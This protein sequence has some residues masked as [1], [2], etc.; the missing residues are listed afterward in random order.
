MKSGGSENLNDSLIQNAWE[1]WLKYNKYY[2]HHLLK[3]SF[4][5][6]QSKKGKGDQEYVETDA[7]AVLWTDTG[8]A[9]M[10]TVV[11]SRAF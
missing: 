8:V 2:R 6:I 3:V 10:R 4:I 5:R 7:R 9:K 1:C 11:I